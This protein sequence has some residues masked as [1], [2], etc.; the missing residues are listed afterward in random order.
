M[1]L[2]VR[3]VS[4]DREC[5]VFLVSLFCLQCRNLLIMGDAMYVPIYLSISFSHHC[6]EKRGHIYERGGE[7]EIPRAISHDG[8][9]RDNS[10]GYL[11]GRGA[12]CHFFA[13]FSFVP[14]DLGSLLFE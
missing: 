13:F 3:V 12:S 1:C 10:L 9:R 8:E 5:V 2:D 6:K 7:T 14:P 11:K 4:F